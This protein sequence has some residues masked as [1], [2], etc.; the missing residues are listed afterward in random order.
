MKKTSI[1]VQ[2]MEPYPGE[3]T[4]REGK[5]LVFL[6]EPVEW[7]GPMMRYHGLGTQMAVPGSRGPDLSA[8]WRST[9]WKETNGIL[10]MEEKKS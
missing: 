5:I 1:D 7:R 6:H 8:H 10:R 2:F 4:D 3:V 9:A